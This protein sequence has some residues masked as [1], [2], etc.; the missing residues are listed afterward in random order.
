MFSALL[1]CISIHVQC[2]TINYR[3][4][5]KDVYMYIPV[6]CTN[7]R[8]AFSKLEETMAYCHALQCIQTSVKRR[9]RSNYQIL[10]NIVMDSNAIAYK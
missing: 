3:G 8:N 10:I 1:H 6:L 4:R 5:P 2:T 9:N 7:V